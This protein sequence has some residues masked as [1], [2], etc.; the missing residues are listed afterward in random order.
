MA[1]KQR[2]CEGATIPQSDAEVAAYINASLCEGDGASIAQALGVV[3]RA[4]GMAQIAR[5]TGL[6]RAHLYTALSQ[7]GNASFDTIFRVLRALKFD[8]HISPGE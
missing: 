4:K 2:Q 3:A 8:L 6:S 5:D 1:T 7:E